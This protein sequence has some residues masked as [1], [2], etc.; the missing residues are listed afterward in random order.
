MSRLK[1]ALLMLLSFVTGVMLMWYQALR[2]LEEATALS[3]IAADR[4]AE[5]IIKQASR[6]KQG[7]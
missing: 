3:Q 2:A 4:R 6:E 1:V 5:R 7:L